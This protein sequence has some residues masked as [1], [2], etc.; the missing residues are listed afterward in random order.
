MSRVAVVAGG[1][2]G[3]GLAVVERLVREGYAVAILARGAERL[4]ELQARF[5]DKVLTQVCN[6]SEA[7][8][9]M[10]AAQTVRDTLGQPVIWVNSAMLTAF[11]PFAKMAAEEFEKITDTTYHGQVNGTRAA[12]TVMDAGNIVNIGSGLSYRAVPMQSAYCGAKHAINGF[13]SAVRSELI[14]ENRGIYLSLVQLPAINTPQFEWARNRF[15]KAPQPAPPIYQPEVAADAVMKAIKGNLR[16]VLVGKS[17]LQLVIGQMILPDWLDKKLAGDGAD[18]QKSEMDQEGYRAGNI[19]E[20]VARAPSAR[21]I[22]G[23]R[24]SDKALI[25]D[26]DLVRK[27]AVFGG[28]AVLFGLGLIVG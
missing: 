21:G 1:S 20:P 14:R 15:D 25:M 5:G 9:V 7:D 12:L 23:D 13:T 16:E 4:D 17:V 27:I 8:A 11:S 26:A 22:F 2:A 24:A 3:V 19:D 18:M 10:G 28:A 6:V